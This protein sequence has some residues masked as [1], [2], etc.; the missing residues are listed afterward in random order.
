MK[1]EEAIRKLSV[2]STTNGSGQCTD[3]EHQEAKKMAISALEKQVAKKPIF[4][5]HI[6][7]KDITKYRCPVC[8]DILRYGVYV[9]YCNC[10]Q[11]LDWSDE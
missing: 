9:G 6:T 8:G 7:R 10:G 1:V 11:K 5:K 3:N 2:Y 4:D